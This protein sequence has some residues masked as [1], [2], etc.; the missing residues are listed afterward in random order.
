[1]HSTPFHPLIT[2]RRKYVRKC[3]WVGAARAPLGLRGCPGACINSRGADT[4]TLSDKAMHQ[5]GKH[6][7][8]MDVYL[9]VCG[10]E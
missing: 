10:V 7:L 4:A 2:S 3:G 5:K 1:M 9:R 8:A 6:P